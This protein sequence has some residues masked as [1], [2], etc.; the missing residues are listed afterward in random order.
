MLRKILIAGLFSG[1]LFA[2][3]EINAM[4]GK[5]VTDSMAAAGAALAVQGDNGEKTL[6][7]HCPCC[8]EKHSFAP[9]T[10]H[11]IKP[12]RAFHPAPAEAFK[13][14][15]E[16]DNIWALNL[17]AIEKMKEQMSRDFERNMKQM[18]ELMRR[19]MKYL[20]QMQERVLNQK[21]AKSKI[22]VN[23]SVVF[24][25]S[26]ET[27]KRI[28]ESLHN[29]EKKLIASNRVGDETYKIYVKKEDGTIEFI[30]ETDVKN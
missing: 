15:G 20:T 10:A 26:E 13:E 11:R 9:K 1:I 24:G 29:G 14:N 18:N 16:T 17:E 21:N 7:L 3:G 30:F 27:L 2:G 22:N 8:A 4:T 6:S 5:A 28:T 25:I 12:V 19:T 23:K